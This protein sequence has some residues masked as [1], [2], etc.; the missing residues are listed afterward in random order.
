MANRNVAVKP[1]ILVFRDPIE[2]IIPWQKYISM[3]FKNTVLRFFPLA[4]D[5][6]KLQA[7]CDRY[8]N[9]TGEK[10]YAPI[11]VK[12][13]A[14]YVLLELNDYPKM[15]I[16]DAGT[17]L[18]T[19]ELIFAIPI[20]YYLQDPTGILHFQNWGLVFAFIYIDNPI[21]IAIGREVYGI[22]KAQVSVLDEP[23]TPYSNPSEA[24][25]YVAYNLPSFSSDHPGNAQT[26]DRSFVEIYREPVS[27]P[28][29]HPADF[30]SALPRMA[31]NYL[32][33]ASAITQGLADSRILWAAPNA[34]IN[35]LA[36]AAQ[37]LETFADN[38]SAI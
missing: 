35:A 11:R 26:F 22:L 32:S 36:N 18:R 3:D 20:E 7:Y 34:M 10:P 33:T 1:R 19:R 9:F 37:T 12:A 29:S 30:F 23:A 17:W 25:R 5:I 15:E 21:S 28:L 13:A 24:R 38:Q 4:A 14:P 6:N 16:A 31:H 8:L 2:N 27:S